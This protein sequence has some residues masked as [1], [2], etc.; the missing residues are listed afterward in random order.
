MAHILLSISDNPIIE[1]PERSV[2]NIMSQKFRCIGR[3]PCL[4]ESCVEETIH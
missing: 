1:K 4:V 3:N 2:E